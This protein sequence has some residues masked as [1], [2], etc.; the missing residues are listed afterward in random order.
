MT[1]IAYRDGILAADKQGS[2]GD[3]IYTATKIFRREYGAIAICGD[4]DS[5][6]SMVRWIDGGEIA[7]G[8]PLSQDTD[9]WAQ[10]IVVRN[11]ELF[12]YGRTPYPERLGDDDFIAFG[13]GREA[14]LGAME[15]GAGAEEAVMVASKWVT[16]CGRGVDVVDCRRQKAGD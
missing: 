4:A 7:G 14:A 9:R 10:L 11:G 3:T 1:V 2:R 13:V 16:G 6:L 12:V 15:M 8:F 5:A